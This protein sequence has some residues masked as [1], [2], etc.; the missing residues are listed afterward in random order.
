MHRREKHDAI[1][2]YAC[3]DD[4]RDK[5]ESKPN[6]SQIL[7]Q[8]DHMAQ[9]MNRKGVEGDKDLKFQALQATYDR[10]KGEAS[11]AC[12]MTDEQGTVRQLHH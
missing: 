5:S 3:H 9:R 4:F 11:K 1:S 8:G 6:L 12:D 7:Q 10:Q 2:Q